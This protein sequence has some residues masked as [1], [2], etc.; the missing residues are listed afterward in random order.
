LRQK[1]GEN[2]GLLD[3]LL[4]LRHG[5]DGVNL[6]RMGIHRLLET[7]MPI[8]VSRLPVARARIG[9]FAGMRADDGRQ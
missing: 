8:V 7:A 4:G 3:S 9:G 1:H 2:S 5:Y 6:P